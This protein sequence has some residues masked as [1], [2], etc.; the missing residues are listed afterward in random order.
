MF[1][2]RTH[3]IV[4]RESALLLLLRYEFIEKNKKMKLALALFLCLRSGIN[5]HQ[6]LRF[7][8]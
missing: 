4:G 7:L 8:I 6:V 2:K 5:I 1:T 3:L